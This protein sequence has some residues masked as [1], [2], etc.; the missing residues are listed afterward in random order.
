MS[1]CENVNVISLNL[2]L[3]KKKEYFWLDLIWICVR[4]AFFINTSHFLKIHLVFHFIGY[5]QIKLGPFLYCA[6][7]QSIVTYGGP[8]SCHVA[9][10]DG[11]SIQSSS[12]FKRYG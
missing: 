10:Y 11:P 9:I 5:I 12:I 2:S 6:N 3:K 1:Y 4:K 7:F 8:R